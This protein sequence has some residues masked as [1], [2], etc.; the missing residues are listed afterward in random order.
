MSEVDVLRPGDIV[1]IFRPGEPIRAG[2][3]IGSRVVRQLQARVRGAY[4]IY[5]V[6]YP[7]NP[8]GSITVGYPITDKSNWRLLFISR[9]TKACK[10]CNRDIPP[11]DDYCDPC[12]KAKLLAEEIERTGTTY[13]SGDLAEIIDPEPERHLPAELES[14]PPEAPRR[15]LNRWD[16]DRIVPTT[17]QHLK[18]P[19]PSTWWK[20]FR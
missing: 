2:Y 15:V 20:L 7:M 13:N 10:R 19:T 6:E 18:E 16:P 3:G 12:F 8:S 11:I 5:D 1:E 14:W 9:P 17:L 4:G